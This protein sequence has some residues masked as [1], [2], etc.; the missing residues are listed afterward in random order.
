MPFIDWAISYLKDAPVSEIAK[1]EAP[2]SL[3]SY[4]YE[5]K[6]GSLSRTDKPFR[7]THIL[8]REFTNLDV[9]FTSGLGILRLR[10]AVKFVSTR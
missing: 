10:F 9:S 3:R 4:I 2:V 1:V 5:I 6:N 7:V 8:G